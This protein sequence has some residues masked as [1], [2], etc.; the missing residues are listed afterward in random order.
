MANHRADTCLQISG[1]PKESVEESNNKLALRSASVRAHVALLGELRGLQS[2]ARESQLA[3]DW[4]AVLDKIQEC[5]EY[6]LANRHL[7]PNVHQH[8]DDYDLYHMEAVDGLKSAS[9]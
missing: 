6:I 3:K 8:M 2:C 5:R 1:I 9:T 7:H 4:Q